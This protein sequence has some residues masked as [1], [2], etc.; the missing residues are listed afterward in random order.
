VILKTAS[1]SLHCVSAINTLPLQPLHVLF[2]QHIPHYC[3]I[4]VTAIM[5]LGYYPHCPKSEQFDF[6]Y[7]A[8]SAHALDSCF[9]S[10]N[11]S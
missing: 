1:I 9:N 7:Y 8:V 6:Q 5:E 4:R 2:K 3:K 11:I 10:P